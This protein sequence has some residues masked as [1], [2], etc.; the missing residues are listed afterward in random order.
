MVEHS[1]SYTDHRGSPQSASGQQCDSS[2]SLPLNLYTFDYKYEAMLCLPKD[3]CQLNEWSGFY[4]IY[5]NY[6]TWRKV[7]NIFVYIVKL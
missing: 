2:E 3:H 1:S 6:G 7:C 5:V 4:S